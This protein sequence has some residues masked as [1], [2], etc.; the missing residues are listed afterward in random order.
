MLCGCILNIPSIS[1]AVP[2]QLNTPVIAEANNASSASTSFTISG[3][4]NRILIIRVYGWNDPSAWT[5]SSCTYN[6]VGLTKLIETQFST[7]TTS[8]WIL[9]NPSTGSNTATCTFSTSVDEGGIIINSYQD[10]H[11]TTATGTGVA[12]TGT[13]TA[14]TVNCSSASDELVIDL[15]TSWGTGSVTIGSGQTMEFEDNYSPGNRESAWGSSETGSG[16][17]TMS[18]TLTNGNEW[19]ETCLPLKPVSGGGPSLK[20]Y[21][22]D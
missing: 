4:T 6:S 7:F 20:L 3:G 5:T 16:T 10:V 17:T 22:G 18:W 21:W 2:S 11:Q 12:G 9:I 1:L 19:I 13:S 15:L 8:L 14:P